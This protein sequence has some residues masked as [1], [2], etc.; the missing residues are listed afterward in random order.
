MRDD[1]VKK[2]V[3]YILIHKTCHLKMDADLR[4]RG[5]QQVGQ[6]GEDRL[7]LTW[8]ENRNKNNMEDSKALQA[9]RSGDEGRKQKIV[10]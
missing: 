1:M 6:P 7:A 9:T 10:M 2:V 8:K 4:R 5:G 3:Y